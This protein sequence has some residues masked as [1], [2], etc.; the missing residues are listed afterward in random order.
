VPEREISAARRPR[1]APDAPPEQATRPLVYERPAR[2]GE[3]RPAEE[4]P[5]ATPTPRLPRDVRL[6]T[7]DSVDV[8]LKLYINADGVVERSVVTRPSGVTEVD[9]LVQQ[10]VLGWEFYPA[11]KD[12]QPV[13]SEQETVV[14]LERDQ[15]RL[16]R[17]S[18]D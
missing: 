13:A 11:T 18:R 4:V 10:S 12:G 5:G 6:L 16:R 2:P 3:D 9:D 15:P 1:P 8:G 7:G 17:R 14:T